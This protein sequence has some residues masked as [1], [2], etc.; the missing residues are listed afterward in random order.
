M[1]KSVSLLKVDPMFRAKGHDRL[2]L[3]AAGLLLAGSQIALAQDDTQTNSTASNSCR[4]LNAPAAAGFDFTSQLSRWGARS[5]YLGNNDTHVVRSI[6]VNTLPIFNTDDPDED[7]WLYRVANDLHRGTQDHVITDQLLFAE[8]QPVTEDILAESERILRQ[9]PY[10]GDA[11]IRV[12]NDC[13]GAV[14]LEVV[15]HEVWTLTPELR[16]NHSGGHSTMGFGIRDANILG[17]GQL[18]GLQYKNSQE[19]SEVALSYQNPNIGG[20]HQRLATEL[21]NNSDGH[22]YVLDAGVPWYA[23]HDESSWDTHLE[24][25]TEVLNQYRYGERVS[26]LVHEGKEASVALGHAWDVEGP[27]INRFSL[28]VRYEQHNLLPGTKLPEPL[29][30]RPELNLL[31]PFVQ[32]E[33][34]EDRWRQGYNISQIQRT[35]DLHL[36]RHLVTSVGYAGN[37][38][39]QLIVKGEYGDTLSYQPKGILQLH[40]DWHGRWQQ[41]QGEWEDTL[42]R[43]GLDYHRGQSAN[44]NLYLGL[45]ATKAI[46]L[47]NGSQLELGGR[48][49]LRGYDTHYL[50]GTGSVR[51]TAE[52]RLFTNY[53]FLQLFRVGM[54]AFYDVG[55]IYGNPD[56]NTDG[57]FQ[58]VG[59]GLRLSPS[60]SQ[61]GQVIHMD[62]AYPLDSALPGGKHE[63]QFIAEVKKS[64]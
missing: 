26:D 19:R 51:F 36:G 20:T 23:L 43:I 5:S 45:E 64:F 33:L 34:L 7:R 53:H 25:T 32:Y 8:G 31:Y 10:I 55:R 17:T 60:R 35:E 48:N 24:S 50:Q 40:A 58:G 1:G 56:P 41:R 18:V 39:R 46:N 30:Y 63:L 38:G 59:L 29:E 37:D 4:Q 11:R 15:T 14:D 57:V 21:S 49:G 9:R 27:F 52:E 28:G 16:F 62:L 22:R 47:R 2:T 6:A 3:L 42:M 13:D 61:S 54:A 44:R 12:L